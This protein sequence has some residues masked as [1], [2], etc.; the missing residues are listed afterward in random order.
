M[1][2]FTGSFYDYTLIGLGV[3]NGGTLHVP[4]THGSAIYP[5]MDVDMGGNVTGLNEANEDFMVKRT[6][7]KVCSRIALT[8]DWGTFQRN[9]SCCWKMGRS[10]FTWMLSMQLILA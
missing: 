4:D 9:G 1:S 6:D 2:D 10:A 3:G 8:M 5:M 7:E